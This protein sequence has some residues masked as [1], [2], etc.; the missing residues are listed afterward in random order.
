VSRSEQSVWLW[1]RGKVKPPVAI[2]EEI[3]A[4]LDCGVADFFEE[5]GASV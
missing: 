4:Y 2:L 1:E 3:A 5:D